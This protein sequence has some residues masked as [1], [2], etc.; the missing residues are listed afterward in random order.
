MTASTDR[1]LDPRARREVYMF[2]INH[3][4]AERF[5]DEEARRRWWVRPKVSLG[6]QAPADICAAD[7]DP[8]GEA[9]SALWQ[10]VSHW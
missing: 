3:C 8:D 1:P 10:L 9:A 5:P 6:G 7:F 4:V 2:A